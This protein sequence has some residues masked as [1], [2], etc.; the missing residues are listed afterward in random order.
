MKPA[1]IIACLF[2]IAFAH[3]A[4][5]AEIVRQESDVGP[6]SYNYVIDT[7]DGT[8]HDEAGHLENAGSENEAI[9]VKGSY[10]YTDEKTG[11]VFNVEYV[12]DSTG[13]HP[14]G[15]HLPPAA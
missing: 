7:S 11:E 1:I 2:A 15:A 8:H 5:D 4:R 3:P 12:A 10:H 13:F 9:A 6:E 14:V